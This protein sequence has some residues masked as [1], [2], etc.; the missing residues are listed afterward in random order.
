MKTIDTLVDDIYAQFNSQGARVDSTLAAEAGDRMAA[1]LDKATVA[2]TEPREVGK[3]WASDIGKRCLR[4]HWYNFNEP[5]Q[6][7]ELH[8][9]TRFKFLYG[10]LL[11]E[12]VLH[13]AR[14]AGHDVRGEQGE[15]EYVDDNGF[16]VRGRID[17]IIDGHLVDVK[18]TSSYGFKRYKDGIDATNDSFGYREQLAF[19]IHFHQLGEVASGCG[20][21][22]IDKQNGHISYT[23]CKVP[24]RDEIITKART[25]HEAVQAELDTDVPRGY[26]PQP[27]GKSGNLSLPI[28][29]SYCPF[30]QRCYRDAN[31][32]RGLRGFVYNQG[33]VWFAEVKR[34]PRATVLEIKHD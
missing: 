31:G 16:T 22:W 14:A 15:V 23:E 4:Q 3:Y 21:V 11:E 1:E 6:G 24:S 29:C 27:Y 7:E 2:R 30:K 18:S 19:Y 33:P 20:F 9:H 28:G 8:G 13:Y 17:A 32:G 5:E 25:I 10:N 12:A 26:S 34:E